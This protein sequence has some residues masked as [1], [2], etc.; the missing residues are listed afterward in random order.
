MIETLFSTTAW[1]SQEELQW[2][3]WPSKSSMPFPG[4]LCLSKCCVKYL[5]DKSVPMYHH[6]RFRYTSDPG[7]KM[8]E[9]QNRYFL[10]LYNEYARRFQTDLELSA[11]SLF[12]FLRC[13]SQSSGREAAPPK[14]RT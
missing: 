1:N 10:V 6:F 8:I 7:G 4:C 13:L 14:C 11:A 9:Q 12:K 5:M 2:S 3:L